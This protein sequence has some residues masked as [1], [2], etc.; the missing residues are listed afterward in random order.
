MTKWMR[1]SWPSCCGAE[2]CDRSTTEKMDSNH[3]RRDQ[4]L[5]KVLDLSHPRTGQRATR[6]VGL[7]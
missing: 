6:V 3:R 1:A 4:S 7:P 5:E 2:C